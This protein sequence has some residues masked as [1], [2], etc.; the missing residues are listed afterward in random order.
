VIKKI[1]M[2]LLPLYMGLAIP[3]STQRA[4]RLERNFERALKTVPLS[5][6]RELP[7]VPS[8]LPTVM[9]M[10]LPHPGCSGNAFPISTQ[11]ASGVKQIFFLG[12]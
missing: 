9:P 2:D 6:P 3:L 4:S 11:R 5:Y 1:Q 7:D 12:F 10:D 8:V